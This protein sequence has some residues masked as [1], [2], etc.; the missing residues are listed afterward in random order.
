MQLGSD[1]LPPFDEGAAQVNVVLPPGTSLSQS[2]RVCEMV[3]RAFAKH[4]RLADNPQGLVLSF[5]RRTGRADD[6]D[7]PRR[8]NSDGHFNSELSEWNREERRDAFSGGRLQHL[9]ASR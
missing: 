7:A 8:F 5:L 1:F 3:D 6:N 9:H 2:N 4:L